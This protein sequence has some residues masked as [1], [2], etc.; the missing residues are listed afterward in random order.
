MRNFT[1]EKMEEI[2]F[3]NLPLTKQLLINYIGYTYENDADFSD[4]SLAREWWY[5]KDENKLENLSI[6]ELVFSGH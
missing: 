6:A 4:E 5:L 1:N 2:D 3:I